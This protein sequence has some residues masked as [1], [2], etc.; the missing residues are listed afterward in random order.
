[1]PYDLADVSLKTGIT[2]EKLQK[3]VAGMVALQ[4]LA[5]LFASERQKVALYGGTALNKIYF[6]KDQRISY[7]LD[8]ES[9]AFERSISLMQR[10]CDSKVSH[11][12]AARF[13]YKGVVVDL[14]KARRI[15]EP[16]LRRV[17]SLLGF[18]NYP[19]GSLLVPS[20]SLE[21][22]L[23]RK[24]TALL[25]RLVP[26]DV[27]DTW[28]G[29]KLLKG[30]KLYRSYVLKIAKAERMNL[31]YL[32]GQLKYFYKSGDM[33]YEPESI[34]V[35]RTVNFKIMIGDVILR[36]YKIFM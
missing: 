27:Y 3:E 5:A 32:I 24:T 23:A 4:E 16:S 18:F 22:L 21:L 35:I 12:K 9:F 25:S 30:E 28:M 8:I 1:M 19:M 34:D 26:K 29:L 14:T 15:E 36:L 20:Y 17:E 10:V 11:I 2:Q 6:G 31:Q 7:D 13:V 33:R